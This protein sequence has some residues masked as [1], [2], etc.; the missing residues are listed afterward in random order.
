VRVCVCTCARACVHELACD[1][2]V[3]AH[4][5]FRN[6]CEMHEA[7]PPTAL[8]ISRAQSAVFFSH[9]MCVAGNVECDV[10]TAFSHQQ[11]QCFLTSW[12]IALGRRSMLRGAS[13]ICSDFLMRFQ[14][15]HWTRARR[16]NFTSSPL[17][18]T[19]R[20][21]GLCGTYSVLGVVVWVV[22]D[23]CHLLTTNRNRVWTTSASNEPRIEPNASP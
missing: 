8:S 6:Q 22:I 3:A 16:S 4:M 11:K 19:R 15:P 18:S 17:V 2:F 1:E 21:H 10:R 20:C 13:L 23:V 7:R 12:T 14:R 5:A 9:Q